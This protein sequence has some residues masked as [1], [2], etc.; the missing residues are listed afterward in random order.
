MNGRRVIVATVLVV[1]A[2]AWPAGAG[3]VLTLDR[4]LALAR[5][6]P[7]ARMAQA[8][9]ER[10]EALGDEA[11]SAY[12]PRLEAD[13]QG[14][15]LGSDLGF[16]LPRGALGNPVPLG[17]V[18]A[19]R[20]AWHGSIQ[21]AQLLWD[22]GRT[23]ARLEAAGR[24]A[25]AARARREAVERA[26][27]LATVRAFAAVNA[28]Q[29][30]VRVA[31][32]A[33]A[34][35]RELVRQVSALVGEEQLPLA[36]EMQAKAAL[37]AARLQLAD[38]HAARNHAVAALEELTGAAVD[39]VAGLPPVPAGMPAGVD[40]LAR[41]A[42]A[43]RPEI[44]ALAARVE[45]LTAAA[46]AEHR[47]GNPE[48]AA[49]ARLDRLDDDYQLHKNNAAAILALRIPVLTGGLVT[50]RTAEKRAEAAAARAELEARKR[51]VRREVRDAA[52]ELAAARERCE[53]AAA[54]RKA[55]DEA[56]REARLRY[57]EQLI[58]NRE[59]LD[60]ERDAIA[61][62]QAE[63][64]ARTR[65]REAAL[66]LRIRIGERIAGAAPAHPAKEQ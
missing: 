42:L 49:V 63:A 3:P 38:A 24:G 8:D 15:W 33:V 6:G 39:G 66:V 30:L 58:T 59:L 2:S 64:V 29:A 54:G 23:A 56:L 4:A 25:A 14:W 18:S 12:H 7:A 41:R 9:V 47:Q 28:T 62:R 1:A 32:S 20:S 51:Q 35:Y 31:E 44:A 37:A 57:R 36:D 45:A 55:A 50:S 5:R 65:L 17:I 26:V 34:D 10:A 53:A 40:E 27:D 60:A 22:G 11:R 61:A 21:L 16:V 48:L 43:A 52:A 13:I 46:R 19:E